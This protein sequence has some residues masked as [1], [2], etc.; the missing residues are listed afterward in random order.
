MSNFI[1]RSIYR[2]DDEEK[3]KYKNA[4]YDFN[5]WDTDVGKSIKSSL[6]GVTNAYQDYMKPDTKV[7]A[8]DLF[9]EMGSQV[10]EMGK[11]MV[12]TK[13]EQKASIKPMEAKMSPKERIKW[14]A[15]GKA[16]QLTEEEE[17]G[18]K[19]QISK[20]LNFI[21]AANMERGIGN[22]MNIKKLKSHEG[23]DRGAVDS[24]KKAIQQGKKLEPIKIIQ[25]GKKWGIEDGK[26]RFQAYK[27][28]G[29]DE[30]PIV[31]VSP[32]ELAKKTLIYLRDKKQKYAGSRS[33]EKLTKE[34]SYDIIDVRRFFKELD[35][36]NLK[37]WSKN[38]TM[39][40]R[41][42]LINGMREVAK[43]LKVSV[44]N[45]TLRQVYNEIDDII[46]KNKQL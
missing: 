10:G 28:L 36:G 37:N 40:Y 38:A 46:S 20:M 39:K 14:I 34:N 21:M 33:V 3:K 5:L 13:E 9:R 12:P 25:E 41:G 30:V 35:R 23:V 44:K 22:T 19:D 42:N 32:R 17:K 45:K 1:T 16:P 24:Y 4:L 27:E 29:Y 15:T 2:E 43:K 31:K 26:H 6:E 18:G 11:A 7:R 8:R